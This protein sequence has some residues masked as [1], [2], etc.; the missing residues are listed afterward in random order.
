MAESM[1]ETTSGVT[2]R[3]MESTDV[4]NTVKR[5]RQEFDPVGTV[6]TESIS[7]CSLVMHDS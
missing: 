1:A 2:R 4:L 3:L 6:S 5:I 7:Y